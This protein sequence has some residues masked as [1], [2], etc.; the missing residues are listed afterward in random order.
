MRELLGADAS[1]PPVAEPP[2]SLQ[3]AG[4][5]PVVRPHP[6]PSTPGSTAHGELAQE[7][8]GATSYTS[9]VEHNPY[10]AISL[11][12]E[13]PWPEHDGPTVF[14]L[15]VS[16]PL[17]DRLLEGWIARRAPQA[18]G[19][20]QIRRAHLPQTRRRRQ[21]RRPDPR[22]DAFLADDDDPLLV[23]MRVVWL[24]RH[25]NGRRTVGWRDLLAF[26]DPRDPDRVRQ[27]II[28]RTRPD[29]CRIVMGHPQRLSALREAWLDPVGRGRREGH[30]VAEFASLRAWLT[31]ERAERALRGNHYK[32]PKFPRESLIDTRAFARGVARL[33]KDAGTTYE[34]M[35]TR[36]GRYVREVAATHTP[37]VIDLVVGAIRWVVDKAYVEI[38]YDEEELAA[39][40]QMSQHYPLVFLPSHKSNFDHLVLLYVFHENGLPP[41]HTAGGINLNFLPVGPFL[42]RSGVFFIRRE[43]KDNAPY[44]FVLRSYI[45]YLLEKRFPLE[46]YIEGSRSRT[47]KLSP[48][49]LGLLA[50]AVESFE[51]G[52]SE[53]VIFVPVSI[54]YDQI[55]EVGSYAVEQGGGT[56]QRE[57]F[58]W[59]FRTLRGLRHRHGAAHVRLGGPISLS[60][61][62]AAQDAPPVE[63]D[64]PQNPAIP[65]LAFEVSTHIN[66]VTP[67]TPVSLVALALLSIGDRALT[68]DE[69]ADVLDPFTSY[70]SERSLPTTDKLTS[71]DHRRISAT[72]T[73]LAAHDV[74]AVSGSSEPLRYR[75]STDAHLTAAY[76]RNTIIHFFLSR[77]IAEL[78]LSA[79]AEKEREAKSQAVMDE[80]LQIRDLLKFEFFFAGREEFADLIRDEIARFDINWMERI[81]DGQ[82]P[83]LLKL[84]RPYWSAAILRPFFD[85]YAIVGDLIS[86][87]ADEPV[88]DP[89][90]LAREASATARDHL[91]RGILKSPESVSSLVIAAAVNLAD[92]RELF[93]SSSDVAERRRAFGA[94]LRA[95]VERL[96]SLRSFEHHQK[97]ATTE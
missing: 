37:Y 22:L 58:G 29:L 21:R 80:A 82:A 28:F 50:Y 73:D 44:K 52:S 31:L 72:L 2:K 6:S 13:P 43:F 19:P 75:I 46:W 49:R 94:Q 33:A 48:P 89:D 35:A 91:A 41:N 47:G 27:H 76:Y 97:P 42:R 63:A 92:N 86:L 15:E 71:D 40:Y 78:A 59:L 16:G 74:V 36:T 69:L 26:G 7:R 77:A 18:D 4:T 67:I 30:G 38:R 17:E 1:A 51:R 62:L 45:D 53:D 88:L 87:H 5:A 95:V 32:V 90:R 54:A 3:R 85:A 57:S 70:V 25:R 65:R 23:P 96:D 66:E 93:D 61:F 64:N 12:D 10:A 14:L 8:P 39:L 55:Q 60:S 79:V 56:K 11:K 81:A 24:P 9:T 34:Q 83:E 68:V 20:P 84:F